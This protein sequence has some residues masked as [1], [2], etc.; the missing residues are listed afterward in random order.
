MPF[1]MPRESE[2]VSRERAEARKPSISRM[3]ARNQ[4][5][6]EMFSCREILYQHH[7]ILGRAIV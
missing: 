5:A 4:A 1:A 3:T 2:D 6:R 7:L